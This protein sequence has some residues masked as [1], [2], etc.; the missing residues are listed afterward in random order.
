[1]SKL[2]RSAA[3]LES[4]PEL[5]VRRLKAGESI[6]VVVLSDKC[7][8]FNSHW[9]GLYS[10]LCT[11]PTTE[12]LGHQRGDPLR[13][14]AYLHVVNLHDQKEIFLELT[15][16]AW[17]QICAQIACDQSWRGLRFNLKRLAGDAARLKVEMLA[18]W[19]SYSKSELPPAKDPEQ[20]LVNLYRKN[21]QKAGRK[22]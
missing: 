6:L 3:P 14:R 19:A 18:P 22:Q 9:T 16:G 15:K 10:T 7:E 21:T 17:E 5:F 20:S 11:E 4:G 13:W 1:M 12:C 8:G 2:T